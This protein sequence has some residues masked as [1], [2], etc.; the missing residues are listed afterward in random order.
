[1]KFKIL[2]GWRDIWW[3]RAL[4]EDLSSVPG[5]SGSSEPPGTS[6]P[7]DP[8]LPSGLSRY[9]HTYGTDTHTHTHIHNTHTHNTHT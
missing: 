4:T 2:R 5:M 1:M 9:L 7:M 8:M 3:L 6:L